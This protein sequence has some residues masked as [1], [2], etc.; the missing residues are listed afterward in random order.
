[1]SDRYSVQRL[2]SLNPKSFVGFDKVIRENN[3]STCLYISYFGEN[4]FLSILKPGKQTFFRE[5]KLSE[6]YE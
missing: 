3:N 4:I 6:S 2:L 1:M 5:T